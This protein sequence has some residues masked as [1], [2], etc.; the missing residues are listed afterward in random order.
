MPR[1][2]RWRRRY[3]RT[4]QEAALPIRYL[5][6]DLRERIAAGEVIERPASVVKELVENALDAGA[7]RIVIEVRAGGFGGITVSDDGC[8]IPADEL[9]LA[10]ARHATSKLAAGDDLR[11]IAT[12]GF[13]GEALASIAAVSELTIRS[14]PPEAAVGACLTVRGGQCGASDWV[15]GPP[16]TTVTV[17]DL[18]FNMPARRS[19]PAIS[20][21]ITDVV[22]AYALLHPDVRWKFV[23]NG[24]VV[25]ETPGTGLTGSLAA[26]F[27][28]E[29]TR[30][31]LPVA[32]VLVEGAIS[33]PGLS[34]SDRRH[35]VIG[36]NG[37]PVRNPALF[38]AVEAAY[39]SLL[40]RGR[41]PLGVLDL[42]L[43]RD[44]V[45]PNIHPA[46]LEVRIDDERALAEQLQQ[47]V[48]AALSRR[49]A[50]PAWP[51]RAVLGLAGGQASFGRDFG[52]AEEPAD[53]A[54][55]EPDLTQLRAIGQ[56][57]NTF[58]IALGPD[59]LYLVDQHRAHERI[60]YS[61]LA[62]RAAENVQ[63]PL[64]EG[65]EGDDALARAA[66]TSALKAG[67]PL[68]PGE[69]QELLRRLALADVPTTCPH[70]APTILRFDRRFLKRQFGRR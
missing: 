15:G 70:G 17:R 4:E 6:P 45:D 65:P 13:R 56:F 41:S 25:F 52:V 8:G 48:E 40:P 68:D 44:R 23:S 31:L 49:L 21:P 35:L 14:R 42:S 69:Q 30:R 50:T 64:F 27:G 9:P 11:A 24:T 18:F 67:Q 10:V 51:R 12:L 57:D 55:D 20:R 46:K 22:A 28:H 3:D 32:S 62:R 60:L 59:G 7:R 19:G 16:G 34:R 26:V 38:R 39:R 58:I 33:P 36:V 29:T 53:Y 5:P 1:R 61:D 37:R 2:S 47:A 63:P 54:P 66:C 43:D